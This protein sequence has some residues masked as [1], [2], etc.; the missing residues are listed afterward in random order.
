METCPWC[1]I[2]KLTSVTGTVYWELPDGTRAVEIT[3]TPSS[4]CENCKALFQSD[5]IV[6]GIEDHITYIAVVAGGT[7]IEYISPSKANLLGSLLLC[8]IGLW[9]LLSNHFSMQETLKNPELI[10]EDRDYTISCREAITLG[11]ILSANC[12]ASGIAIGANGI[13]VIWT[14]ISIGFFSIV[15]VGV[16]SHLGCL[17]IKTFVGKYSTSFQDGYLL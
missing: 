3:E 12:L 10:D 13:S 5:E 6:K 4:H 14:V 8:A 15:T 9:T 17:L 7:I 16:G 11:F 2:G 1:E